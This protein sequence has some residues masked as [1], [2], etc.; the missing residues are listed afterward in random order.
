MLIIGIQAVAQHANAGLSIVLTGEQHGK[1]IAAKPS[2]YIVW[3][4]MLT[5]RGCKIFLALHLPQRAPHIIK[6]LELILVKIEKGEI[7]MPLL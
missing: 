6:W 5:Q 4:Q 7:R 2:G 3:P 1:L